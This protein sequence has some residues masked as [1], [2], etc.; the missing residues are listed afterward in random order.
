MNR[1]RIIAIIVAVVMLVSVGAVALAATSGGGIEFKD[2]GGG[3]VH[4]PDC[5][6]CKGGDP[7]KVCQDKELCTD[8]DCDKPGCGTC[9]CDCH[10]QDPDKKC[11]PCKDKPKGPT[12]TCDCHDKDLILP[13]LGSM[14][15]DFGSQQ[16]SLVTQ[17]YESKTQARWGSSIGASNDSKFRAA[18][19]LV[20]SPVDWQLKLSI[21]P[22]MNGNEEVLKGFKIAL[23]PGLFAASDKGQG[24]GAWVPGGTGIGAAGAL[25][26]A[27][28]SPTIAATGG[29][30]IVATGTPGYSG[31]N[32]AGEL[33]VLGNTAKAGEAKATLTW[34]YEIAP[35]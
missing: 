26:P 2:R 20:E 34:T 16:I 31:G 14:D 32:F 35:K 3:G 18:G 24:R 28:N 9:D 19:F 6:P 27:L 7:G 10:K 5:C 8:P 30:W 29:P 17:K 1:K 21:G 22:F 33:E 23:E 13:R 12:C 25:P 4:N 15:I 11:C